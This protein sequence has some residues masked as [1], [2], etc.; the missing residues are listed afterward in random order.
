MKCLLFAL[1]AVLASGMLGVSYAQTDHS[2]TIVV[3]RTLQGNLVFEFF[4]EDAPNHVENFVALAQDGFYNNVVFHRIIPGF[5]IQG[6]DPLT[7][8]GSGVGQDRWGTGGP[9]TLLNAEF[10]DIMHNRGILSMARSSNPDSAGSQFFVVHQNSNF[11]DAQYT[12]FGRLATS[13]SYDT[14]DAIA[15]LE[16]DG[17]DRPADPDAARITL[18]E[19]LNRERA[20]ALN[21]L[22]LDPPSR[23]Q[24]AAQPEPSREYTS[25][26]LNLSIEFPEGW[27]IQSVGGA[28]MPD[29]VAV[30]PLSG[31]IPP[32]IAVYVV[33]AG[34]HTLD[35]VR[36]SK[37]R[38]LE[39]LAEGG[40]FQITH[41]EIASISDY[42]A[43][44]LDAQDIFDTGAGP[45]EIKYR[46]ATIVSSGLIYTFLFSSNLADFDSEVGFFDDSLASFSVL[47]RQDAP[48]DSPAEAAP[49]GGCLIATAAF[50]S[51]LA[52]PVQQLRELRDRTLMQTASGSGF[53]SGFNAVY[54]TF[55]PAI[56][57]YERENPLFREMVRAAITP[58]IHI[59]S[60]LNHLEMEDEGAV[61]AYGIAVI[62]LVVVAYAAP[63]ALAAL[64]LR[65]ALSAHLRSR[66]PGSLQAAPAA[67]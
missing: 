34:N 10:N 11:L 46:E 57:D 54:Y 21:L 29:V 3:M 62:L 20:S 9:D 19:V 16:V 26:E 56:A 58:A 18:V 17:N 44:V 30:G 38:D 5:M 15:A 40:T 35:T 1:A 52:G 4:P 6:G 33:E 8:P 48:E 59:L 67:V 63:P 42:D 50:G 2:D 36:E 27:V 23:V 31:A 53:V 7:K 22:D 24:S 55:S 51:E 66:R 14:L 61:I 12:V 25:E 49:G 39:N 45:A 43:F 64:L 65:R 28:D 41:H 47:D 32:N 13:E 37:M 60:V